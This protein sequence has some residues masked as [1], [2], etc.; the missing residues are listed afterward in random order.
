[1]FCCL[2]GLWSFYHLQLHSSIG[3]LDYSPTKINSSGTSRWV[4]YVSTCLDSTPNF[5]GTYLQ[6][7]RIVSKMNQRSTIEGASVTCFPRVSRNIKGELYSWCLPHP[8]MHESYTLPFILAPH[9]PYLYL[10]ELF[11][12]CMCIWYMYAA[13]VGPCIV[14]RKASELLELELPAVLSHP[15]EFRESDS[16]YLE[17][18]QVLWTSEPSLW[19]QFFPEAFLSPASEE[20]ISCSNHNPTSR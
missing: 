12:F 19:A 18:H 6:D 7:S 9:S 2:V 1:M 16:F 8:W 4:S 3:W 14:Q 5:S 10:E 13:R 11:Y 17:V 15:R 20:E